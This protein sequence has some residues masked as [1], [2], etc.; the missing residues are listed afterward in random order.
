[1]IWNA[2]LVGFY[3]YILKDN[4]SAENSKLFAGFLLQLLQLLQLGDNLVTTWWPQLD[5]FGD[6]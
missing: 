2:L 4:L 5:H 3:S 6:N 1:M